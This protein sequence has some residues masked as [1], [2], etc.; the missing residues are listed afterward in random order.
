[1]PVTPYTTLCNHGYQLAKDLLFFI[2]KDVLPAIDDQCKNNP[3]ADPKRYNVLNIPFIRI[4]K[5][6]HTFAKLNESRDFQAVGVGT[7]SIFENYLDIVWLEMFQEDC[8][9]ERFREFANVN[10][11][12]AANNVV[13]HKQNNSAS[14]IDS[15]A[16]VQWMKN[17]D[18][19]ESIAARIKRV[20]GK[21]N[22]INGKQWWPEHWTGVGKIRH[23]ASKLS[24][25]FEDAYVQIYPTLCALTHSGPT[26]ELGGID[27]WEL[28]LSFAFIYGFKYAFEAT[29]VILRMHNAE[30]YVP[31]YRQKVAQ[32][33][34]FTCEALSNMPNR[35]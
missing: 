23:R 30:S 19:Q 28:Q 7:R 16:H 6:L 26:S 24:P 14:Q 22:D 18:T 29:Q 34:Q 5:W 13:R 8:W 21:E 25:E 9:Y 11:Y 4:V 1:M 35:A 32:L 10:R 31:D 2:N 12:A 17:F 33:R 20:W 15:A 27:W 3:N